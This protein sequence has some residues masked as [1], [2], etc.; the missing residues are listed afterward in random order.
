MISLN[1]I[2]YFRWI[3]SNDF[4]PSSPADNFP[5]L[6]KPRNLLL[7]LDEKS[8]SSTQYPY[9]PNETYNTES[10]VG[11]KHSYS[12]SDAPPPLSAISSVYSSSSF[13]SEMVEK[14]NFAGN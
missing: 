11:D 13:S 12:S 3:F 6:L 9:H 10:F 5:A 14:L 7:I 2:D 8:F 1:G 4:L